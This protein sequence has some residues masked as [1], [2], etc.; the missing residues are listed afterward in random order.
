M[1]AL[2]GGVCGCAGSQTGCKCCKCG[3]A[4]AATK[5]DSFWDSDLAKALPDPT[6]AFS[7]SVLLL[8]FYMGGSAPNNDPLSFITNPFVLWGLF[9]GAAAYQ[10][11]KN[12]S[13]TLTVADSWAA[14]WY[15][16]NAFFFHLILDGFGA[17][18]DRIPLVATQYEKLDKRYLSGGNVSVPYTVALIEVFFMAPLCFLAYYFIKTGNP[19]RYVVEIVVSTAQ[20]IGLIVFCGVEIFD[21]NLN[22]P[23]HKPVGT[24]EGRW[25][26]INDFSF[27]YIVYYWFGFWLANAIWA[28]VPFIR[29][30]NAAKAIH[31]SITC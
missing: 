11:S 5:S 29:V 22:V 31:K 8:M 14:N 23:A 20:F 9:L 13:V 15:L 3:D 4:S 24:K 26:N 2:N 30:A 18:F 16:F 10:L 7:V 1:C 25:A 19:H 17:A 21:G 28:V 12:D 6:A 27:D